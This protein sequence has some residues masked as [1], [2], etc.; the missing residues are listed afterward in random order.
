VSVLRT[1]E[2]YA[3]EMA[4]LDLDGETKEIVLGAR[5]WF[6]LVEEVRDRERSRFVHAGFP[7]YVSIIVGDSLTLTTS[8]GSIIVR[9]QQPASPDTF[10]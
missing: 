4:T 1:L 7:Q 8:R 6:K 10:G 5:A 3:R 9:K 2:F